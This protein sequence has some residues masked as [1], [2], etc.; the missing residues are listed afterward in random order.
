[1]CSGTIRTAQKLPAGHLKGASPLTHL[2]L[3]GC[4]PPEGHLK[5][6]S[7]ST[8]PAL[9][10]DLFIEKSKK[11]ASRADYRPVVHSKWEKIQDFLYWLHNLDFMP[12]GV[13]V[14][15]FFNLIVTRETY[16]SKGQSKRCKFLLL[17]RM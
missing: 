9:C 6:A 11:L 1:M 12:L 10:M 4:L 16:Y 2:A 17:N 15:H 13:A 7:P 8:P 5:R 3:F 14:R